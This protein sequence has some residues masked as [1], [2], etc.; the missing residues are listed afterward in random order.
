VSFTQP[1]QIDCNKRVENA[2]FIH[3]LIEVAASY[4]ALLQVKK[5]INY[6]AVRAVL[7]GV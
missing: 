3:T 2:G 6:L 1:I 5:G 7:E 4:P